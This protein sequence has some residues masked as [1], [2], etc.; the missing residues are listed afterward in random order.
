MSEIKDAGVDRR[1]NR[2][3]EIV[4]QNG[5][6]KVT[7]LA[8]EFSI[9]HVTIRNDLTEMDREGLLRRVHGGAISI[10]KSYYDVS[11]NDRMYINKNEKIKIAATVASL[12]RDGDI[13]MMDSGTTTCYIAR[14]LADHKNLTIVTNSMHIARE[15]SNNNAANLIMVGGNLDIR[16]QFTYGN[17]AIEQL[18]RYR[19]NKM[20]LAT[21]G[22]SA[23]H[24]LTAYH[25]Q[26][27]GVSRRMIDRANEIIAV[28]DYSKIGKEGFTHITSL[29]SIDI[30]ITNKKGAN[31]KELD[32]IR[33][34][35]IVVKEV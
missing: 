31:L 24:G 35:G 18:K 13:L 26:E 21:D 17:D 11:L 28:A 6:A 7:Q 15:F 10:E 8:K 1:R 32:A 23:E 20:I 30:L 33:G 4:N 12:V 3:L 34:R 29:E 27:I 25:H 9:S 19:A 2:I 22:I 14:A 16:Y 5:K